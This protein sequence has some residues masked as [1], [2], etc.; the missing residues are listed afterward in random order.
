M[1]ASKVVLSRVG[2]TTVLPLKYDDRL[3]CVWKS[4]F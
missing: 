1:K 4:T 2:T 3:N